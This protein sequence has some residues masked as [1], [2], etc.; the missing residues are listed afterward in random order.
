MS[1]QIKIE[2]GNCYR[3]PLPDGRWAYCQ[4]ILHN[5]ELGYLVRV[6][7]LITTELLDLVEGLAKSGQ[8]FHPCSLAFVR[9]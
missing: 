7:D 4:Y 2:I 9:L 6:F 8:L 1:T 3:I 5:R